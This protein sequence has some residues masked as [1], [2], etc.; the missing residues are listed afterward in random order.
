M[1]RGPESFNLVLIGS[2][3]VGL[4]AVTI[5]FIQ[6][7]FVE[8][9]DPTIE[10]SY[11]KQVVVDDKSVIIDITDTAGQEEYTV[12]RENYYKDPKN[13]F[14]ILM[15]SLTSLVSLVEL[16][17]YFIRPMR[18]YRREEWRNAPVLPF[19]LVGNKKDLFDRYGEVD[20]EVA[21]ATARAFQC[22]YMETS[23]RTGEGVEEL[24]FHCVREWRKCYDVDG[25]LYHH[26]MGGGNSVVS[27]DVLAKPAPKKGFLQKIISSFKKPTPSKHHHFSANELFWNRRR[28]IDLL[29]D[30][31][32]DV[33]RGA[34]IESFLNAHF[35]D[36]K[37]DSEMLSISLFW[38]CYYGDVETMDVLLRRGANPLNARVLALNIR[39]KKK[40]E[41]IPAVV[42]KIAP[43]VSHV[44]V[45][46]DA[47]WLPVK[48]WCALK[49]QWDNVV[50]GF[51][52]AARFRWKIP[53]DVIKI[54]LNM[55]CPR[56]SGV[57]K[58]QSPYLTR[59]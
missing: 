53:K 19:V 12:M 41:K 30:G 10:D 27:D 1:E 57:H 51:G 23:A 47:D 45:M 59:M 25:H 21:L 52:C 35:D 40:E 3:G 36:S 11:R 33:F 46:R 17:E 31:E 39:L 13:H 42:W 56:S 14:F 2:G 29:Q 50:E 34:E 20:R 7:H 49:T 9:Y 48:E 43:F 54:I 22:P 4:S 15:F 28:L 6:K 58:Y 8:E 44:R 5:Q 24:F 38:A 16:V 26:E 55:A 37:L 18:R 32:N